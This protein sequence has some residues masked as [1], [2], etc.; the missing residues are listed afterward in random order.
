VTGASV[1]L[2]DIVQQ[3]ELFYLSEG[4]LP[5]NAREIAL[6]NF[7]SP[8]GLARLQAATTQERVRLLARYA[9]PAT[10]RFYDTFTAGPDV[11]FGHGIRMVP[12]AEWDSSYPDTSQWT[13]ADGTPAPVQYALHLTVNGAEPGRVLL[14][15]TVYFGR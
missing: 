7:D 1:S 8:G 10:G 15:R 3:V 6:R 2:N 11:P 5:R 14:R 4:H 9:C 13:A 12:K